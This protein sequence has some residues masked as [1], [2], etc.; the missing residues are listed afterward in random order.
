MLK[1][2]FN[3]SLFFSLML[4]TSIAE[5]VDDVPSYGHCGTEQA[6]ANLFSNDAKALREHLEFEKLHFNRPQNLSSSSLQSN[7]MTSSVAPSYVIPVVF[8][9]Y[10]TS[11][12]GKTVNDSIIIDALN[13]TNKDFQGLA[14]DYGEII[15]E[16]EN[17]KDVF[18]VEF[19]LAKKDPSGRATTGINYYAKKSGYGNGSGYDSQIRADAWDNYKYLNVYIQND[20]YNDG[21]TTNSGV[22]WYPNTGMSNNN[23]A[24]VVYNGAYL[25][26]NTSENFRSVLT[27]EFGHYLNLI[28]TFQ[29]GCNS[30]NENRCSSTG[31]Q[32]CDTPQVDNS[33]LQS[34][35]CLGQMTNWQNFMH[36]SDQYANFTRNQVDRMVNAMNHAARKTLWTQQ[37]LEDTGT[38]GGTTPP[39]PSGDELVN[40]QS[41]SLSGAAKSSK[42]FTLKVPSN[43]SNLSFN[44]NGGSGDADLYVKFGSKPTLN[45]YDCRPYRNGNNETCDISNASVGTYHVMLYG[46]NAYSSTNLTGSFKTGQTPP[47]NSSVPNACASQSPITSG[48]LKDGVAACLGQKN[49]IG[50][51]IGDVSSH[52]TI[53]ITTGHGSGDLSLTYR[54]GGWP[55]GSTYDAKSSN[56]GN[57]ECIYVTGKNADYWSYL[58]VEGNASGASIIVD[59]DSAACR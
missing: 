39:P 36:Y 6:M 32:I 12:N 22:A 45:S 53:A 31:D 29:G 25:G 44:I 56:A 30:S 20:L 26:S 58:Y 54:N 21:T 57:T 11:F 5:A 10:G 35:N 16:F 13:K 48:Q 49:R 42:Y 2:V 15:P 40:G 33:G 28:H 17:I 59:F 52:Q 1:K 24:R 34:T 3:K 46:Y 55:N 47:P 14:A 43:A 51:Y 18:N 8:H 23:T 37:N 4:T 19:R 41:V 27:H 9:V 50:L 38:D 7:A